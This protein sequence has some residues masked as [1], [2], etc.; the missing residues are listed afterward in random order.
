[1]VFC[2]I[3]GPDRAEWVIQRIFM[4][5]SGEQ[6]SFVKIIRMKQIFFINIPLFNSE[7]F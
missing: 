5:S 4:R 6:G 7:K 3:N 2:S 1:M